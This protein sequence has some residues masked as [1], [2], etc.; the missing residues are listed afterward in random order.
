MTIVVESLRF[1][2]LLLLCALNQLTC[3]YLLVDIHLVRSRHCFVFTMQLMSLLPARGR[4]P[5]F[6]RV[7]RDLSS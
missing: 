2:L 6:S 3:C 4:R 5:V 1:H 7:S